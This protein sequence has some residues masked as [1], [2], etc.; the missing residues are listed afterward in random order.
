M[1]NALLSFFLFP[2]KRISRKRLDRALAGKSILI[3]GASFGIGE[4]VARLLAGPEVSLILVAR[5]A[6]RLEALANEL[7][8]RGGTV[9]V[10][11][12]DLTDGED[13]DAFVAEL[14]SQGISLDVVVS[15]AGHSI[16]R[17]VYAATDRF[18]D[19]ERTMALNYFAPVRLLLPLLP[20]LSERRGQIVNVSA[21]NVLLLPAP[22]WSAYQA[23]KVA[24]DQWLR[25][26]A[27]ELR[28][29]GVVCSTAYLPLVRTRMIAPTRAYRHVPAMTP[30]QA[31][32]VIGQLVLHRRYQFKPWWLGFGQLAGGLGRPLWERVVPLFLPKK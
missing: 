5:T 2:L 7:E 28:P 11:A 31:A 32:V 24:F 14:L 9:A 17:S 20:L 27:L 4:Q 29:R 10:R 8:E 1:F 21:A 19:Y 30:E 6:T 23:S 25:S 12:L 3:T 26:V 16:L 13:V 15:N 22:F 18:H